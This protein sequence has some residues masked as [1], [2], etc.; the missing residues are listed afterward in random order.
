MHYRL[1][2]AQRIA[3]LELDEYIKQ[4][5]AVIAPELEV[6]AVRDTNFQLLYRVWFG[7]KPIGTFYHDIDGAWIAQLSG[8]IRKTRCNSSDEAQSFIISMSELSIS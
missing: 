4:Q 6:D 8:S 2:D 1:I 5:A 3:Q 7:I